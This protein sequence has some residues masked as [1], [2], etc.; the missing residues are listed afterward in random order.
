MACVAGTGPNDNQ[1]DCR[2]CAGN[3]ISTLGT[4]QA[5]GRSTVA[6]HA[7]TQ[8]DDISQSDGVMDMSVVADVIEV[9]G[10][11]S[12]S[13]LLI[14][15]SLRLTAIDSA[16]SI[17]GTLQHRSLATM[18]AAELASSLGIGRSEVYVAT[19]IA[20][21]S[22]GRR[23]MQTEHQDSIVAF[24]MV[25]SHSV[26]VLRNLQD[27]L[28]DPSSPLLNSPTTSMI[29]PNVKP[30]FSFVCQP[31]TIRTVGAAQCYPCPAEKVPNIEQSGCTACGLGTTP[32]LDGTTCICDLGWYSYSEPQ[33]GSFQQAI[34]CHEAEF[35]NL[36]R[37]L[38]PGCN[39]CGQCVSCN[40][41]DVVVAPGYVR[42]FGPPIT[43][44]RRR[45]QG[46]LQ[47]P[48][49]S[50]FR[51]VFEHGCHAVGTVFANQTGCKTCNQKIRSLPLNT[52]C[53]YPF[54]GHFCSKCIDGYEIETTN[55]D[56]KCVRCGD[57]INSD[58]WTPCVFLVLVAVLVALRKR[59]LK[60]LV[61]RPEK[62]AIIQAIIRS[63]I[64]PARIMITYAQITGALGPILEFA[65]PEMFKGFADTF[66]SVFRL[67]FLDVFAST[68]CLGV[69]TFHHRF[70]LQVAVMPLVVLLSPTILFLI[71][72]MKDPTIDAAAVRGQLFFAVF[73][74]YPSVCAHCFACFVT[75][76]IA[77]GVEV[78]RD[79]D[80]LL[81]D[82]SEHI[83]YRYV[84]TV[85]IVAF[86]FGVPL[87]TAGL[88]F[89]AQQQLP[90]VDKELQARVSQAFRVSMGEAE[91]VINDITIGS[92]Y[93]FLTDAFK[94]TFFM[95]ETLDMLRKLG[96]VGGLLFVE[97]GSVA[98]AMVALCFALGFLSRHMWARPYKFDADN[99]LRAATEVHTCMM[100][101]VALA[102][103]TDL[104]S[105]HSAFF[106]L[107]DEGAFDQ[108]AEDSAERKRAYDWLLV[109][110]FVICV[111]AM[112]T[113][114]MV[115]KVRLIQKTLQYTAKATEA[116]SDRQT[117]MIFGFRRFQLGLLND[118]ETQA[119]ADYIS[120]ELAVT[121]EHQR[122][123][124]RLWNDLTVATHLRSKELASLLGKI[125][126]EL[127]RS[128]SI[129]YHFTDLD[130]ANLI[131]GS[132]GIRASTVGQ[133]GGGVSISLQ[134]PVDF[135]WDSLSP[136][137]FH[138]RCGDALWG[139]K[140]YE[141]MPGSPPSDLKDKIVSGEWMGTW[142]AARDDWGKWRKK[143]EVVLVLRIPSAENR[144][145]NRIVPGRGSVYIVPPADC[146]R[147]D[148]NDTDQAR[149]LSNTT[150]EKALLLKPPKSDGVQVL[151]GITKRNV[152]A[153]V[154]CISDRDS[155][156]AMV[157]VQLAEIDFDTRVV[158]ELRGGYCYEKMP[159]MKAVVKLSA[160]VSAT[161]A[162][163]SSQAY[164]ERHRR[165]HDMA[166]HTK[167]WPENV[168]RFTAEEMKGALRAIEQAEMHCYTILYHYCRAD[169]ARR[170]CEVGN[171][172]DASVEVTLVSPVDLGWKKFQEGNFVENA[173]RML[174]GDSWRDG[175]AHALQAVVIVAVPSNVV[176][177]CMVESLWKPTRLH[178][179]LMMAERVGS[180]SEGLVYSNAFVRKSYILEP[181]NRRVSATVSDHVDRNDDD[182]ATRIESSLVLATQGNSP[183]AKKVATT[184]RNSST[185]CTTPP[186]GLSRDPPPISRIDTGVPS[187]ATLRTTTPQRISRLP[188]PLPIGPAT[189]RSTAAMP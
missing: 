101:A 122:A 128:H 71:Q 111:P 15:T 126:E 62:L 69:D 89:R 53:Q 187:V 114:T 16:A 56:Y 141:V 181:T 142:P 86:A 59:L 24:V 169:E 136:T 132:I 127:P 48:P 104:D 95:T 134:S 58:W 8:C 52:G 25:S 79:D 33:Y 20:V 108:F 21:E 103:R 139:T 153:R 125:Q 178:E 72:R 70:V 161:P 162:D 68:Q 143:L 67:S 109:S 14:Q 189:T 99:H 96:L 65:P 129:G 121:N 73:L 81:Y 77:P 11:S 45:L 138:K 173:G 19:I 94:P 118:K 47:P 41:P 9:A 63:G 168:S 119:L 144:D 172:L 66:A 165:L 112:F 87:V 167:H 137:S 140:W 5:C 76:R 175:H 44:T 91:A 159:W 158:E 145:P 7:K 27:Q 176:Q 106:G 93:G 57:A 12:S 28:N 39:K 171:G 123:G 155:N 182:F 102:F 183:K 97:P 26:S 32:S 146:V 50:I 156:G 160:V 85:L 179:S 116:K 75:L 188:P 147:N 174:W 36:P 110:T 34:V 130:S 84:A 49:I 184:Q 88:L 46:D 2:Q 38:T 17:E 64:Q 164:L 185:R 31:G 13:N 90:S 42:I 135:E 152:N 37:S 18:F 55:M 83:P 92:T 157:Q 6:N 22:D 133:L 177:D 163:A 100:I 117:R 113:L 43:E 98:Q 23:Q 60:L 105:T 54:T 61:P 78:L 154:K 148:F 1:T 74:I 107:E 3:S 186:H 170:M 40:Y 166:A 80:R 180:H 115:R 10:N 150:I 131:L 30:I 51:C 120:T 29:D 82:D 151:D 149:Y 124:R 4:C 35:E